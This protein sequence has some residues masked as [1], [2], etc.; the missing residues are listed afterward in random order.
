MR[1]LIH[2]RPSVAT[3]LSL[4]ALFAALGGTSYAAATISGKQ[5]KNGTLT[6]ADVKN[7]SLSGADQ[8]ANTLG[9]AQIAESKLG[10]VPSAAKASQADKATQA[11]DATRAQRATNAD[12]AIQAE[13]ALSADQATKAGSVG[14]DGVDSA[15]IKDNAITGA[16]LGD[17]T[18]RETEVTIPSGTSTSKVTP[19]L[20]GETMLS[21]GTYWTD[22]LL[23]NATA[24]QLHIVYSRPGS[25]V[26]QARG[27]NNT[28][29]NDAKLVVYALCLS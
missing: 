16:D 22:V 25:N 13:K 10:Q 5:V 6:G 11:D 18:V 28:G 7:R 9:G 3:V 2:S 24:A 14:P 19:C 12:N 21:G 20:A 17:A 23:N 4:I 8:K 29:D 1:K 26:W 27:Y 15:A